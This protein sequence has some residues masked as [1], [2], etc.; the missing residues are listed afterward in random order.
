MKIPP[1]LW[2]LAAVLAAVLLLAPYSYLTGTWD[3][4]PT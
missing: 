4:P 1:N 3:Q 2:V